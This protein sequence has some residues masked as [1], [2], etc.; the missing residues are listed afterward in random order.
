MNGIL[1]IYMFD[2]CDCDRNC[3]DKFLNR[4]ALIVL[5]FVVCC[6]F[7]IRKKN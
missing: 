1:K 2:V 7:L 6:F 3:V 4:C 5:L